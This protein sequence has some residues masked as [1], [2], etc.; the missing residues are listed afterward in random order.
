MADDID[1]AQYHNEFYQ[2][3][4]MAAHY[5]RQIPHGPPLSKGGGEA[6]GICID[7]EEPIPEARRRAMPG[8]QR[9]I[10]CQTLHENWRPL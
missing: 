7:C 10:G 8:C 4:A 2:Q 3:H 9:C 6:G 5:R 1:R